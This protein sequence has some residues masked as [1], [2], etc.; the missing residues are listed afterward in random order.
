M[1]RSISPV[2]V[3]TP[4]RRRARQRSPTLQLQLRIVPS[5]LRTAF[6]L[7][8]CTRIV[9]HSV[10]GAALILA[11]SSRS[12]LTIRTVRTSCQGDR[13]IRA[14]P[15]GA[16]PRGLLTPKR[17]A[18]EIGERRLSLWG[19]TTLL[20]IGGSLPLLFDAVDEY[21]PG[22]GRRARGCAQWPHRDPTFVELFPVRSCR[23]CMVLNY[24]GSQ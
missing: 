20:R 14:P 15:L 10:Q 16:P 11:G 5:Q 24:R 9:A 1:A 6:H 22:E 8:S 12:Q 2:T 7:V 23:I 3:R 4:G 13:S 19:A 21:G 18:R 17:A